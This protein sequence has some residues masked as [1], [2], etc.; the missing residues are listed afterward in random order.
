MRWRG[1]RA[2]VG[3][4]WP[5]HSHRGSPLNSVVSLHASDELMPPNLIPSPEQFRRTTGFAVAVVALSVPYVA[6]A[7]AIPFRGE[8]WF[9]DYVPSIGAVVFGTLANSVHA[10]T[11]FVLG[12]SR[13]YSRAAYWVAVICSLLYV[14]VTHFSYF[15]LRSSSTAGIGALFIPIYA[16]GIAAVLWLGVGFIAKRR[17]AG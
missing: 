14:A 6:R 11:L 15:D 16:A 17:H 7:A 1:P 12:T 9:L 8:N 10:G 3:R 5:R 4:V 13:A 2:I